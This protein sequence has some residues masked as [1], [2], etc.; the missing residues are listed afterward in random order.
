MF[1]EHL[2]RYAIKTRRIAEKRLL[3]ARDSERAGKSTSLRALRRVVYPHGAN[4][5]A[6]GFAEMS[7]A[8]SGKCQGG[9]ISPPFLVAK[10]RQIENLTVATENSTAKELERAEKSEQL[11]TV[12]LFDW[13]IGE[14]VEARKTANNS[15]KINLA[16]AQ[17]YRMKSDNVNALLSLKESYPD[18]AQMF[19]EEMGREE[20]DIF[21][22]LTN[23]SDIK[24]WANQRRLDPYQ[25]AGVIRPETIFDAPPKIKATFG[26][27]QLL[28][29]TR[30]PTA[31][32]YNASPRRFT[33]KRFFSLV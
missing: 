29:P 31:K 23:W 14:L 22:P 20:W 1:I 24:Y 15:P 5:T 7:L 11:S 10:R 25:V 3:A 18:Y 16:L 27:M 12:G 28:I 9:R 4:G 13:A 21:Y 8:Q 17:H 19:P 26:L 2:A 33:A 6:S 32:R 30:A